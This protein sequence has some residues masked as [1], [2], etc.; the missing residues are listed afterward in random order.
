M[1]ISYYKDWTIQPNPDWETIQIAIPEDSFVIQ[2]VD[3]ISFDADEPEKQVEGQLLPLDTLALVIAGLSSM[4]VF[5]IPAVAGIAGAGI[6]L[7]KFRAR[8]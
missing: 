1:T 7:V 8:D 6:Y 5:M 2:V 3:T 4:T